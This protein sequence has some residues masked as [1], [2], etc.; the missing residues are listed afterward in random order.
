MKIVMLG[1]LMKSVMDL[2]AENL[3]AQH[4]VTFL[5]NQPETDEQKR[6]YAEAEIIVGVGTHEGWPTPDNLK[7][8]QVPNA[9]TDRVNTSNF[10]EGSLL[11]N[12]SG[13]EIPIAEYIMASVLYWQIPLVDA[14]DRM[15]KNDWHYFSPEN[16]AEKKEVSGT[17]M[18]ILGL[19]S[20]GRFTAS[21]AKA[22]GMNVIACN[23]EKI[24]IGGDI[25]GYYALDQIHEF[26]AQ[27]DFLVVSL[28]LVEP[29]TGIVNREFLAA[30][31]QDAVVINVGRAQLI[32]ETAMYE[33]LK[34]GKIRGAVL[35]P[36]YNYPT[37]DNPNAKP[38]NLDFSSLKNAMLTSHM[39]GAS[40]RLV[41]RRAENLVK[42]IERF[43]KG[44]TPTNIVKKI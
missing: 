20:I 1:S 37:P 9:G 2:A 30:M 19:G 36:Q 22:F 32:D 43:T 11:C 39:S 7:V 25:D 8:W 24:E 38:T 42:N 26:A 14:F 23:R 34:N 10:P 40:N 44:E 17:T 41:V 27:V 12:I 3:F 28:A 15:K 5:P 35:D 16:I 18:G 29:T 6:A 31:K 33:A 4:T 13:H 21:R